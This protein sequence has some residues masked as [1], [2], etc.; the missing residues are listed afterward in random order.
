M[1][2]LERLTNAFFIV[3]PLVGAFW[4]GYRF[5]EDVNQRM[6]QINKQPIG[7]VELAQRIVQRQLS[8]R[9]IWEQATVGLLLYPEDKIRTGDNSAARIAL[10]SGDIIDLASNS[11]ITLSATKDGGLIQVES[12]VVIPVVSTG[13]FSLQGSDGTE[14]QPDG[15][16]FYADV[17]GLGIE[18]AALD[19][20]VQDVVISAI[21]PTV[22]L[23]F[24]D[25]YFSSDAYFSPNGD[26]VKDTI[27]LFLTVPAGDVVAGWALAVV[28][29]SGGIVRT[30]S[31]S[32]APPA[33]LEFD[34]KNENGRTLAEGVYRWQLS[35]RYRNNYVSTAVSPAFTVDL[36]PPTAAVRTEYPIFSPNN[37]GRKDEMIFHQE[38]S[39][40]A[41]WL[42]EIRKADGSPDERPVRSVRFTGSLPARFT[43]NGVTDSGAP[44]A[45]GDYVYQ[46]FSTDQAGNSGASKPVRFSLASFDTPVSLA[47][48]S[49]AFSPAAQA[50]KN[51]LTLTPHVGVNT[52]ITSWQVDILDSE[53]KAVRNFAGSG[54]VP[55]AVSWNGMTGAGQRAPDGDYTANIL[56]RYDMGNEVSVS[57]PR[58]TLDTIPPKGEVSM[59]Y[60]LFSPN[61]DGRRD[62]LPLSITTEGND[63]WLA[64][65][66]DSTGSAIR[67]WRWRGAAPEINWDGADRAGNRA[68]DGTYRFTLFSTDEA[69]N[70]FRQVIGGIV[71]DARVPT[72][73]L[74]SSALALAPGKGVSLGVEA[75]PRDGVEF[76]QLDI[77]TETGDVFRSFP[78]GRRNAAL[79]NSVFWNGRN[80]AGDVVEGRYTPAL[81]LF[82]AKGDV[83]SA[84]C[85]PVTVDNSGP[86]LTFSSS[87]EYFSPDGDGTNDQLVMNLGAKDLSSIADWSLE[88]RSPQAPFPV[89]YRLSGSGAPPERAVW[90][91]RSSG[92]ELVQS[93]MD[94]PFTFSAAD[95]LGNASRMEGKIGVDV[96]VQRDGDRMRIMVPSIVFRSNAADF[97]GLEKTVVDNNNRI[98][99]RIAEILNKFP[100]Y[101]VQVEGHAN[102]VT[103]TAEEENLSLQPLSERRAQATV[104]FLVNFGVNR[105]RLSAIGMGGKRPVVSYADRDEWWKNRRVE[106]ILIK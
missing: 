13:G 27:T 76:W 59:F 69:G 85:P 44:A 84:Q 51:S 79:P 54:P 22:G 9:T 50:P 55:A 12:G 91:G 105:S 37:D 58:F 49:G 10:K 8:T 95:A 6:T 78:E 71:L 62:T 43:W 5:L 48:N 99:R 14:M 33:S 57:S 23:S 89:F 19:T 3:F 80:A 11:F 74:S 34:G 100:D 64:A 88:I 67:S 72:A 75:S 46:T 61:D 68:P 25:G 36:S 93:A 17:S 39:R 106:F 28:N 40:E 60:T 94:Y 96:L 29:E 38:S 70:A 42:G 21:Q 73:S 83:V 41:S 26:G 63:E 18:T 15:S 47:V 56:V 1:R 7:Q 30:F 2:I 87:P 104:D 81:T 16:G 66:T 86:V 53:G 20:I 101:K 103:R 24:T 98:L 65:F 92:G 35:V 32:D 82:Y 90:D 77:R 97:A 45:E 52:G 31:G 4:G 102:A